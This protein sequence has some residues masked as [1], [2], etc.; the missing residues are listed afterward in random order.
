MQKLCIFLLFHQPR[1][2]RCWTLSIFYIWITKE[3]KYFSFKCTWISSLRTIFVCWEQICCCVALKVC[4]HKQFH[5]D[6][7][8][9]NSLVVR[10]SA[11]E[12][13]RQE[14]LPFLNPKK[15]YFTL[16]KMWQK[17]GV[18]YI[19]LYWKEGQNILS[20]ILNSYFWVVTFLD[21]SPKYVSLLII[22]IYFFMCNFFWEHY[23]VG[24]IMFHTAIL[25]EIYVQSPI[26]SVHFM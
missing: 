16:C 19:N 18:N 7:E 15:Y 5:T 2:L 8:C 4:L 14:R 1:K 22:Y 6:D 23:L 17:K 26:I 12:T 13:V 21:R 10:S 3:K 25:H 11:A 20:A 9:E 24:Q